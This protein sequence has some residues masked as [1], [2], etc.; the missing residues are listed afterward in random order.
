MRKTKIICTIGPAVE[1]RETLKQLMLNGMDCARLNFSHGDYKEHLIRINSI[2]EI[3]EELQAPIPILLD[4][5]GPEIRISKF[6]HQFVEIQK[7]QTFT[8][9]DDSEVIGNKD[10]VGLSYPISYSVQPGTSILVDDGNVAFVVLE[11][12]N[13]QT[14][15]KALN[16]GIIS[17]RKSVNIPNVYIDMPY[18][19][20]KDKE[21]IL[22]GI[23]QGVDFI[24]ASFIRKAS[25]VQELRELLDT[26]NG[27]H[28]KIISKI[29]NKQGIE[30]LDDIIKIS[31]GIMVA[32][33]DLGVEI[34]FEDLPAIQKEIIKKCYNAGKYVITATQMLESMTK[35]PRPTRAEVSDVANAIYDGTTII[36]L[37]GETAMGRYPIR[38][39][40]A[41]A[42]IAES[43]EKDI[44][45]MK[46]FNK[47]H[48]NL[49]KRV[50]SAI[51]NAA[52]FSAHQLDAKAIIAVTRKGVTAESMANYRST[53]PIIAATPNEC[54]RRQ[55]N[56][57]WNV[58]PILDVNQF[59]N[60]DAFDFDSAVNKAIELGLVNKSEMVVMAAGVKKSDLQT[61]II[62]IHK[63]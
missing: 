41:M 26:N 4:T 14:C 36:M 57:C 39:V 34:P 52:C 20:D 62:K 18:I 5:K 54:V 19:S 2:K 48:L 27:K 50:M 23:Q 59:V 43:T 24:G 8:F 6:E 1:D 7:G 45:Y 22:F 32:R 17:N 37:S 58:K 35:N 56:L 21:D 11:V 51:A 16:S 55:L 49:G 40:K 28:I 61:G 9:I 12:E 38:S 53:T 33:G 13:N 42:N 46:K 47:N 31:D 63:V 60:E 10:K 3:R 30:N 15:C 25:D 29:E 44:D